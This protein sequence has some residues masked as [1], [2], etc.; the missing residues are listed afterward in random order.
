MI[1]ITTRARKW[2]NSL[3]ILLPKEYGFK[4]DQEVCLQIEPTKRFTKVGS[5]FGK[6]RLKMKTQELLREID[7]EIDIR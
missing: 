4:A 5:I 3:G 6:H 1:E 2:G 7:K